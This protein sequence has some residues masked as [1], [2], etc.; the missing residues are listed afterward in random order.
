MFPLKTDT[1]FTRDQVV[2]VTRAM[3]QIAHIDGAGTAEEVALISQF[4][5]G[6]RNSGG[7]EWAG[8]ETVSRDYCGASVSA[9][10]FPD[11]EQREMIIATCIM[12]AFA[13][14]AMT[15]DELSALRKMSEGLS[16][17]IERFDQILALVKDHMLMQLAGLPDTESIIAVT[18]ELG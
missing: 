16:I 3:L 7:D 11:A 5:D 6:F 15:Q 13:D 4:Y 1:P 18:R 10:V 9:D 14:G 12:V 2:G 17:T 8:F